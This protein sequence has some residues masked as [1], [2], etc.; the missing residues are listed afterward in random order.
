[1]AALTFKVGG[2]TSGL[3]RAVSKAKGMLSGLGTA[4]K[5]LAIGGAVAGSFAA[6]GAAFR[7]VKLAAEMEQVAVAMEVMTGSAEKG[8]GLLRH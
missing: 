5:N 8:I 1:M 6:I 4:A 7:G 2:D 3:G